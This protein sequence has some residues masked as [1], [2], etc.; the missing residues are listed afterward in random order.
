VAKDQKGARRE[1][2]ATT[3]ASARD[4]IMS[5]TRDLLSEKRYSEVSVADILAASGTAKGSFYFYFASKEDLL[6]ALVHEAVARGLAAA[7]TWTDTESADPVEALR[8]GAAAGARL[9]RD[10]APVLRAI[11]EARGTDPDLDAAWRGQ[12]QEFSKAALARLE[13]DD[14]AA[15]W[16][17]GR[18][19][20]AVVTALTWLGERVYYLAATGSPPF[21]DEEVVVDVL[22]DLWGLAL[23]GR[24]T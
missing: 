9:W 20:E 1:R 18:D 19:P 16:L 2:P 15:A 7:E 12:M 14:D 24:R 21:D 3:G 10:E 17:D 5:A 4:R 6:E 8:A 23:Y 11:V 22:A 13:G